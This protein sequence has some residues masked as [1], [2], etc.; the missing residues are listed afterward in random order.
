[1]LFDVRGRRRT[2]IKAVY[3]GLALLFL[4]GFIG[5]GVGSDVGAG[6]LGSGHGGGSG[7]GHG[8]GGDGRSIEDQRED[9]L[10]R[11]QANGRDANAWRQLSVLEAGAAFESSG[12]HGGSTQLAD[13]AP[14]RL[15]ASV[16]AYEAYRDLV[17][18]RRV[19][20]SVASTAGRSY[21]TLQQFEDA[22]TAQ[23]L[24]I[25]RRDTQGWFLLAQYAAGAHDSELVERA[26]RKAI[27]SAPSGQREAL[28]QQLPALRQLALTVVGPPGG[29]AAGGSSAP[30]ADGQSA[31][32][33]GGGHGG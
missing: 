22:V 17:G 26:M 16:A 15:N 18:P 3:G 24:A 1:M 20:R 10:E 32:P 7:G 28:R 23:R 29:G 11:V 13:D 9:L 19:E 4:V 31:P 27:R 21:A 8:G 25:G 30:P 2:V 33:R 14:E 12:G 6:L 5:F